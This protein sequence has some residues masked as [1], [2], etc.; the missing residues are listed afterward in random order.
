MSLSGWIRALRGGSRQRL[1]L[2]LA[3]WNSLRRWTSLVRTR[4][5]EM[6][7]LV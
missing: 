7:V 6:P 4:E 2:L 3:L 1:L 5:V